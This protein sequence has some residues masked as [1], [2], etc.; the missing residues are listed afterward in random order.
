MPLQ[1]VRPFVHREVSLQQYTELQKSSTEEAIASALRGE[2][3]KMLEEVT[4]H[5]VQPIACMK[6]PL[7]RLKIEST[8]YS[9]SDS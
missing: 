1:C 5:R 2:V 3:E 7:L 4:Q 9:T 8:G 6:L